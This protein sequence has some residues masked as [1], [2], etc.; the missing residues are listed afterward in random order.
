MFMSFWVF[1][2]YRKANY[3]AN[4]ESRWIKTKTCIS[5]LIQST[6]PLRQVKEIQTVPTRVISVEK[7]LNFYP[8]MKENWR[9]A[10]VKDIS[11]HSSLH[12]QRIMI[13]ENIF[14]IRFCLEFKGKTSHSIIY[15]PGKYQMETPHRFVQ[16]IQWRS[17]AWSSCTVWGGGE[18]KRCLWHL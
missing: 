11:F 12:P 7:L 4:T 8:R 14:F 16:V 10:S 5:L 9:R 18:S 1:F 17:P 6:I 3:K 2:F 15:L 13:S